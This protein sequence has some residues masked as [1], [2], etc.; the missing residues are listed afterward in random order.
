M[1]TTTDQHWEAWGARD[2]YYGV[3]THGRFRSANMT[4][5][6]RA[7]FFASGQGHVDAVLHT[8]RLQFGDFPLERVLDFGCGVGR[9]AIPF[10]HRAREVVALDVSPSMLAEAKR[11][12][13]QCDVKNVRWELSDDKLSRADGLFDLVHSYIVLQ[14]IEIA[15][16]RSIFAAL[17]DRI[18]PSGIGAIQVTF[19][20]D[21]YAD[22]FG[23]CPVVTESTSR[24][25]TRIIRSWR[26][27]SAVAQP[28]LP[29]NGDPEMQMNM[30]NLSELVFVLQRAGA[31]RVL[32]EM[33][34]HGGALGAFLYFRKDT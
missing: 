23:Q 4:A 20:M 25:W 26:T 8:C 10:A 31:Q 1:N 32:M 2:P 29:S 6:A 14:H 30:Y 3:L 18:R 12:A 16:G 24:K 34:N 17:V 27:K 21:A 19:A 9:V 28:A 5:E 7:E 33:S 15:R 11:N 22:S 13:E